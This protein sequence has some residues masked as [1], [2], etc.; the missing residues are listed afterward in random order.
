MESGSPPP[1]AEIDISFNADDSFM[2]M[3]NTSDVL[4]A[5]VQSGVPPPAASVAVALEK[6]NQP[7]HFK[8]EFEGGCLDLFAKLQA[9]LTSGELPFSTPLSWSSDEECELFDDST[10]NFGVEL[11][12]DIYDKASANFNMVSTNNPT[13]PWPS[14]AHFITSLLFSSPHLPFSETQKK[15]ILNWARDLGTQNVPS[16][17]SM[18]KCHTYLDNLVS[19][20]TQQ[21]TS[22]S[23]DVFYINNIAEAIA[24]DYVNPLAQFAMKDYPEDGGEGMSQVFNRKKM[25][26]DLLSPVVVQVDGTIY[27]TDE[28]LQD[29]SGD[30]FILEHFFYTSPP[31][32]SDSDDTEPRK[33]ADM[34]PLYALGWASFEDIAA[35]QGE[36][37]CGLT[38]SSTKYVSLSPSSMCKKANGRMVYTVPLIIFMDNVSGNISKQWNKHHTI[39][40]S[41]ANL[42]C[43]MLEKE[44]F[45]HFVTSLPHAAPMELMQA[46][47]QSISFVATSGVIAWDCKD[48]EEAEECNHAGLNCNYFCWTCD[49]GGMKEF[50]TFGDGYSSL[51]PSGNLRTPEGTATNIQQQFEMALKSGAK[52]K[53]KNSVSS[54]GIHDSASI[55]IINTLVELGKKL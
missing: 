37:N 26:F 12:D 28:L 24:K 17:G 30:Y 13:Y 44:F 35:T 18:K 40:M 38:A 27:F 52:E 47:K 49:V 41:N 7:S 34:K 39:Y 3:D 1:A 45:V 46:M 11:P 31:A 36:L 5:C 22:H 15:A 32:D 29:D 21:A 20:P 51:F 33:H 23:G 48:N 54:M 16:L 4:L 6:D 53:I 9:T 43:E 55:S 25:L 19:N 14:K 8:F 10:P 42:P 2:D 50:K